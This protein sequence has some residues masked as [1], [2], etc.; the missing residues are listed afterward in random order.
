MYDG[1]LPKHLPEAGRGN[2]MKFGKALL[3]GVA[4]VA[5]ATT[6]AKAADLTPIMPAQTVMTEPM[7]APTI[8]WSGPYAGVVGRYLVCTGICVLGQ[9]YE[10]GV[11]AGYN[12]AL[13]NF[14]VGA[15][16]EIGAYIN[17]LFSPTGFVE[18]DARAGILLGQRVLAYA[19]AG[20]GYF[21][22]AGT[23]VTAGGGVELALSNS[24]S[25]YGEFMPHWFLPG[26]GGPDLRFA[27]GFNFHF[28]H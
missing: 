7:A 11:K 25:V 8:A 3:A 14:V 6:S 21:F 17:T 5:L 13:G 12:Y 19:Q 28:G 26:F 22:G 2:A 9:I 27:V 1:T 23:Y 4:F 10:L 18:G 20:F 15:N 24:I 16:A